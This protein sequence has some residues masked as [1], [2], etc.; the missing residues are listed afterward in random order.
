MKYAARML[1]VALTMAP[2]LASAQ[3]GSAN[4][5]VAQVPFEFHAG[6]KTLPAGTT[7][8]QLASMNGTTLSIR[9]LD[10]KVNMFAGS[11]PDTP[12]RGAGNTLVFHRYGDHYFLTEIRVEGSAISYRLP[13]SGQE[14]ELRAQNVPAVEEMLLAQ[15]R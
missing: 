7:T 11:F 8:I 9:N 4:K 2:L 6:S 1:A 13:E 14:S 3:L 12:P 15:L 10:E 5:I